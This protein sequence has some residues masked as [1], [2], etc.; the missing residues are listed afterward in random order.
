MV[1]RLKYSKLGEMAFVSHLDFLKIFIRSLR[2][3]NVNMKYS[4]GF[5]PHPKISFSPALSLGV[6]SI[7]EFV[8]IETEYDY[9]ESDII[10]RVNNALPLGIKILDA[11]IIDK[12][13]GVSN[14]SNFSEYEIKIEGDYD[15]NS[16]NSVIGNILSKDEIII[17]KKNKK[18]KYVDLNVRERIYSIKIIDGTINAILLN[19]VNGALKPVELIDLINSYTT[20]DIAIR[21]IRKVNVYQIDEKE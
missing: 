9:V 15:I 1:I 19:S 13:G 8:D 21:T 6:E 20:N 5:H 2:R 7:C 17:K 16:I 10:E 4:Q 14:I 12:I 18:G 11:K 3:A